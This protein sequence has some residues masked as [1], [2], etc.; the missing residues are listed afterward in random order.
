MQ[1]FQ[2]QAQGDVDFGGPG[3]S[4][5]VG[6]GVTGNELVAWLRGL[7]FGAIE[8]AVSWLAEVVEDV[9]ADSING[10]QWHWITYINSNAG[11]VN[12]DEGG[13][14]V[15]IT[16][17][18]NPPSTSNVICT[19]ALYYW[20]LQLY[21]QNLNVAYGQ[22]VVVW[23]RAHD[24]GR[25]PFKP[26]VADF[27]DN[28]GYYTIWLNT[29]VPL[30]PKADTSKAD[31]V[32]KTKTTGGLRATKPHPLALTSGQV[33]VLQNEDTGYVLHGD[34]M[35][36]GG[37]VHEYQKTDYACQQW[38]ATRNKDGTYTFQA[39]LGVVWVNFGG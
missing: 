34:N 24:G 8:E 3:Q 21:K 7:N 4:D 10:N 27:K 35:A 31:A 15:A 20:Y 39:L 1:P 29:D 6:A 28:K 23:A 32:A 11:K 19:P 38:R 9:A 25:D 5:N 36:S 17:D 16:K 2:I 33:F 13:F 18:N 26:K 14:W 12:Y 22:K 30:G 37:N